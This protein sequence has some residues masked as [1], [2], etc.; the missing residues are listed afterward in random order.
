M[1]T[2]DSTIYYDGQKH[3]NPTTKQKIFGDINKYLVDN[4]I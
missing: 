4:D 3:N 1:V 2:G